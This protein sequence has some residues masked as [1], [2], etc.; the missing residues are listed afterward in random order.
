M[1]YSQWLRVRLAEA[2]FGYYGGTSAAAD[3]IGVSR[4]TLHSW[5][6]GRYVPTG[7]RLMKVA[8]ALASEDC[9]KFAE[10]LLEQIS[11]ISTGEA[12]YRRFLAA[13]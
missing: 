10:L 11:V 13:P 2:G 5:L 6:T 9:E 8:A 1:K 3:V 4:T 12:D 7:D